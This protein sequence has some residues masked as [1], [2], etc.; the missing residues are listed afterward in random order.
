MNT[1]KEKFSDER[2]RQAVNYA[3]DK[4]TFVDTIIEGRGT[5]ANSYINSTI[6]GWSEEEEAYPCTIRK[7]QNELLAEADL[8]MDL[9]AVS[10]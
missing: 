2:V 10:M 1:T 6:P 7:R 8:R 3:L 5:V 9:S 4:Q